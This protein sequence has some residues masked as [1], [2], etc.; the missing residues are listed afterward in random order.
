MH[1][2]NKVK[3]YE[4]KLNEKQKSIEE[5]NMKILSKICSIGSD[6]GITNRKSKSFSLNATNDL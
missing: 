3:A 5:K 2:N 1:K 4:F 6:K